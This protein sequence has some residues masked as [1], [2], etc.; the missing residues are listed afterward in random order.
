MLFLRIFASQARLLVTPGTKGI[1]KD[2]FQRAKALTL[3]SGMGSLLRLLN[4]SA[5]NLTKRSSSESEDYLRKV[6]IG[7][8]REYQIDLERKKRREEREKELEVM[9]A[10]G[11]E[12][13]TAWGNPITKSPDRTRCMY[14]KTL[15]CPCLTGKA[16][17]SD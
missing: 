16:Q 7:I 12:L 9:K 4:S 11:D 8:V 5:T 13:R 1:S 14:A 3:E 17:R 10:A 15:L 6:Q 2:N